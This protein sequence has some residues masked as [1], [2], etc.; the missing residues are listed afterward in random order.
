MF[1]FS[2]NKE[3]FEVNKNEYRLTKWSTITTALE[4]KRLVSAIAPAF[5]VMAD[6]K[7][8]SQ[9][10]ETLDEIIEGTDIEMLL[11]GAVSQLSANFSDEHFSD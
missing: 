4:G 9:K 10:E 5:A 7:M 1:K 11:T 3:K 6:M 8:G 2:K